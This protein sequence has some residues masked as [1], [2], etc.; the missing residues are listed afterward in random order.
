M[1]IYI[2]IDRYSRDAVVG[3]EKATAMFETMSLRSEEIDVN[4]NA[5]S[6]V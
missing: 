2:Y 4:E 3:I 6:A 1:C 5:V